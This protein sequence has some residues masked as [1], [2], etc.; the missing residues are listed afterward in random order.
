MALTKATYSMIDGAPINIKDYG[1]VGDGVADDTAAI[2]AAINVAVS[3]AIMQAVYIPKGVY[4][5]TAPLTITNTALLKSGFTMFGDGKSSQIYNT[6]TGTG[7]QMSS[8]GGGGFLTDVVFRNF[9]LRGAGVTGGRGFALGIG[10]EPMWGTTLDGLTIYDIGQEAIWAYNVSQTIRI[11]N[12]TITSTGMAG[13]YDCI[14]IGPNITYV[15]VTDTFVS[16]N[17]KNGFFA[18]GNTMVVNITGSNFSGCAASGITLSGVQG[19][20]ITGTYAGTGCSTP[21][22]LNNN[23]QGI[24]I[25]GCWADDGSNVGILLN[26]TFGCS[27]IGCYIDLNDLAGIALLGTNDGVSIKSNYFLGNSTGAGGYRS[28]IYVNG[29][30]GGEIVNNYID[31]QVYA[32][33]VNVNNDYAIKLTS[34]NSL[35]VKNNSSTNHVYATVAIESRLNVISCNIGSNSGTGTSADPITIVSTDVSDP[36]LILSRN[37]L[38][39]M[40]RTSL[41]NSDLTGRQ[42]VF[43]PFNHR[44]T[45]LTYT[46]SITPNL[47]SGELFEII[48]TNSTAFTINGPASLATSD[49]FTIL[50]LNQSGGSLGTVTWNSIYKLGSGFTSPTNS[51]CAILKFYVYDANN[52]FLTSSS[53]VTFV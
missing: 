21:I 31:G 18:G 36:S 48:A 13:V 37:Y 16:G 22:V 29:C 28:D 17:T 39:D 27:V 30:N 49:E 40:P 35:T 14:K 10:T 45:T 41:P 11:S 50:L 15:S 32:G 8:A 42:K 1:A 47:N 52:V 4:K 33:G 6:G 19:G 12:C 34:A 9:S 23:C 5:T 46:A 44:R 20:A 43:G 38:A 3:T 51:Q 2:Q 25:N 26:G 7:I 24:S 53:N